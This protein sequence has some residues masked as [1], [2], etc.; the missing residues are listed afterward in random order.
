M[1]TTSLMYAKHLMFIVLTP[2]VLGAGAFA[3]TVPAQNAGVY[4]FQVPFDFVVMGRTYEAARY[5]VGRLNQANPD[6]LALSSSAGK[7]LLVFQTRRSTSRE[8]AG[9]SQLTFSQYG[10]MHFLDSIR[11]S[12]NSYESRVPSIKSDR[13]RRDSSQLSRVLTI[14]SK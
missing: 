7:T 13:I 2:L 9:P 10:Q 8:L 11:T 6:T 1:T 12:G 3:T 4:E 14:S 5:R